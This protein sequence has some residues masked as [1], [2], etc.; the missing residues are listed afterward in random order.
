MSLE[1]N[2]IVKKSDVINDFATNITLALDKEFA[3]QNK[4]CASKFPE[5]ASIKSIFADV[6]L[7]HPVNS[8]I[9]N[10]IIIAN[11]VV[12]LFTNYLQPYTR[13]RTVYYT[14]RYYITNNGSPSY[15]YY[16]YTL[17]GL[18]SNLSSFTFLSPWYTNSTQPPYTSSDLNINLSAEKNEVSAN[19]IISISNYKKFFNDLN[20]SLQNIIKTNFVNLSC[21]VCH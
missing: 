15:Y 11:D 4:N 20:N 5:M 8:D 19:E 18:M 6:D 9:P 12:N 10:S 1:Q 21:T 13:G 16:N 2:K 3:L 14:K 17:S 7:S